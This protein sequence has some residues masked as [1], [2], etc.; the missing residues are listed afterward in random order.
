MDYGVWTRLIT[1]TIIMYG[2]WSKKYRVRIIGYGE[3]AIRSM[4]YELWTMDKIT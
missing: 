2:V 4:D 3:Y 1:N